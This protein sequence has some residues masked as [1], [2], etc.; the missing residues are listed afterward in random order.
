VDLFLQEAA[1]PAD[2]KTV[3]KR[4]AKGMRS[5]YVPALYEPEYHRDGPLK[6]FRPKEA[7]VPPTVEPACAPVEAG[8]AVPVTLVTT[9]ET[10]FGDRVLVEMGRGCGRACRFCAAGYVYR[11]PRFR[12][13]GDLAESIEGALGR[14]Y[15][16]GLLGTAVSDHPHLGPLAAGIVE[17]GCGFSLSSLRADSLTPDLLENLKRA[18]QRTLAIAPEAGSER[19]RAVINKHLTRDQLTEAVRLIARTGDFSIRLYFLIGL[20]TETREDAE[21]IVD[22]VK[23]L[24]HHMVK[25]SAPRGSIG[26]IRLSVNC[27]VPKAFTPFQWFPM[28]D[29]PQLKE[30]QKWLRK[31]LTREGGVRVN[32][33][34]PKWAYVQTLL[35][36]GDRRAGAI[37]HRAH[38]AGGDWTRALRHSD[39]NPDFFVYRPRG[40]E[41]VLP[42]DF[43][44]QG[45]SKGFLASEY[46]RA[47]EGKETDGCDV[48]ACFRCGVCR[49]ETDT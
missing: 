35:S 39:V 7:H 45:I 12:E 29:I 44:D 26:R 31:R 34:M 23:V 19:L 46:K 47:L 43:V 16:V 17:K 30:R 49:P 41:E 10:E 11:P 20:P 4:L 28:T 37:L 18:G 9:P 32:M 24:R 2:R 3:L 21:A 14:T 5:L 6:S 38:E 15:Q 33:D 27:F 25:E 1:G 42:W 22:L 40:L 48:G 13:P 8:E 36:M